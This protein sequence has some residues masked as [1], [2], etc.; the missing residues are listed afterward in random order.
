MKTKITLAVALALTG[1]ANL[2]G[3]SP[4]TRDY[5]SNEYNYAIMVVTDA[6]AAVRLCGNRNTGY[7]SYIRKL[8][9]DSATLVEFVANKADTTQALPAALQIRDLVEEVIDTPGF[10][11]RYCQHKLSNVQASGRMFARGVGS[12]DRF[13]VCNGNVS[14]RFD[15]FQESYNNNSITKAEFMYLSNDLLKLQD[16]D[17]AGCTLEQ[18]KELERAIEVIQSVVKFLL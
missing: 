2:T 8:D 6:T 15:L 5:D 16:I 17:T 14:D 12:T 18:R 3:L 10:S 4:T 9:I 7:E 13:N 11:K 1:C